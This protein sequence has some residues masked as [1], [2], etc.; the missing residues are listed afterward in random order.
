[1]QNLEA[2]DVQSNHLSSLPDGI[3]DLIRLRVLILSDNVFTSLPFESLHRLPLIELSVAKNKLDSVLVS[4][5]NM[6]FPSLQILDIT[7]NALTSLSSGRISFPALHQLNCS[8]NRL[9]SLPEM[10]S[11][12]SLLTLSAEDNNISSLPEGFVSLNKLKNVNLSGNNLKVLDDQICNM[13]SLD[14][15][16]ISGNPLREKKFSGMTTADLKRALRARLAP[17]EPEIATEELSDG[18]SVSPGRRSSAD[19]P[20]EA[21]GVLDR[22]NT[23]SY[24]LNPVI[25]AQ[26][27]SNN[28]IRELNLHHN[29]FKEIPSAI[30]FFA[31]TLTTLSLAHNELTSDTFLK[32]DLELPVLKELNLSSNTFSSVQPLLQRLH[33]PHLEKLDISFNRLTT[34]PVLRAQF[35][36]LTVVLASNNTIRELSPESVKGLKVL[37]CSSNDISSL[38]ARIGLLGGPGGLERLDVRGNRFRVPKYNILDKGTEATLAWLRDRIPAGET[39]PVSPTDVD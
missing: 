26:I 37:D 5:D 21:R 10:T 34:M 23:Q 25:I 28:T 24:S 19:W 6:E 22:S 39:S 15:L 9:T 2:I 13:E 33:A 32:D 29:L 11:W 16:R 38:N 18:P 27:A 17:V 30:G 36:S 1:M 35:P 14:I 12:Q 7:S 20:V 4:M 3:I 8:I 31:S